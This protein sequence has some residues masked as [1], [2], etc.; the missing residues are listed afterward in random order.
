MKVVLI[1]EKKAKL[2][3][4]GGRIK[5]IRT[6]ATY[7]EVVV[8]AKWIHRFTDV[9]SVQYEEV[10][11]ETL[12]EDI[13]LIF[14]QVLQLIVDLAVKYDALEDLRNLPQI[15]I[16]TLFGLANEKEVTDADMQSLIM[17]VV[18]LKTDIEAR[19]PRSWYDVWNSNL[20]PYIIESLTQLK[21][22]V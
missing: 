16:T 22:S 10:P 12:P 1:N 3:P 18:M 21:K 11:I 14:D 15:N 7:S 5:D 4:T 9:D 19:L 13:R 8:P 17:Q 20:K 2:T 6:G